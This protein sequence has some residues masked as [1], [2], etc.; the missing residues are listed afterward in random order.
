MPPSEPLSDGVVVLRVRAASDLD[1][2]VSA[3]HDEETRR[4]LEDEPLEP[5]M[6]ERARDALLQRA[7]DVWVRG[8]AAPLV[9]AKADTDAPAG[10]LNLQSRDDQ[11]ATIAYSVFPAHRGQG[12]APRAVRLVI[13]WAR[14]Q[15]GI[16]HLL[17]EADAEN[18]ASIRVAKKCGF[19]QVDDLL[20]T[21]DTGRERHRLVHELLA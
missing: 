21:D 18:A 13:P 10:L 9:I 16:R 17:L 4:W 14:E 8:D 5:V 11:T 19:T 2:I 20:V 6:D 7:A 15:L 12:I 1:A 3:S